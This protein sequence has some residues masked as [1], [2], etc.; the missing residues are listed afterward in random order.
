V[1]ATSI[2]PRTCLQAD[3]THKTNMH[4]YPT[5]ILGNVN[6]NTIRV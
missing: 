2:D 5:L 3:G 6:V 4:G 1:S